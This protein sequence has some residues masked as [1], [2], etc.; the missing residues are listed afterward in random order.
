MADSLELLV[1]RVARAEADAADELAA[2][3]RSADERELRPLAKH[4]SVLVRAVVARVTPGHTASCALALARELARDAEPLVRTS[5]ATALADDPGFGDDALYAKLLEDANENVRAL[6]LPPASTRPELVDA[7]C[8]ALREDESPT[9]RARLCALLGEKHPELSLPLLIEAAGREGDKDVGRAASVALLDIVRRYDG[10]PPVVALPSAELLDEAIEAVR[11]RG[12]RR[13]AKVVTALERRRAT[14]PA[15]PV[16]APAPTVEEHVERG[17]ELERQVEQVLAVLRKPRGRAVMLV[18]PSGA[19]KTTLARELA[20]C[21]LSPGVKPR[22]VRMQPD[23]FLTG[24]KYLGE[25]QT[26]LEELVLSLE[27]DKCAVLCVPNAHLLMTTGVTDD[28]PNNVGAALAQYVERGSL[29]IVGETTPEGFASMFSRDSGARRVWSEVRL[30][31]ADDARTRRILRAICDES[32]AS[33]SDALLERI[34]DYSEMFVAGAVQPGRSAGLLRNVLER[35]RDA[36]LTL[37]DVLDELSRLSGVPRDLVDDDA[38]LDVPRLREFFE[39][40]VIG[41]SEA[42]DSVVDLVTLFKAGLNDPHKPLAVLLFVGPTGV[43]KTELARAL[44]ERLF[45]DPARLLRFDMSEY[46]TYEAF[47]RLHG[48]AQRAGALTSAVRERPLSVVLLDEIEK[49]HHNVFDL[50]LQIFDAGRL[51]DGAGRTVDFRRTIVIM[52]SNLGS[53]VRVDPRLGFGGSGSD[54]PANEDVQRELRSFFRPEFLARID[55]IV[56]FAPLSLETAEQI[57]RKELA[58]MLQRRGIERRGLSIDVDPALVSLLLREGYTQAFGARPLKRTIERRVLLPVA[59]TIAAGPIEPGAVLRLRVDNAGAVLVDL[60]RPAQDSLTPHAPAAPAGSE[61]VR[62]RAQGLLA[63]AREV[64]ACAERW[65]QRRSELVE[66]SNAPGFWSDVERATRAMDELHRVDQLLQ[67]IAKLGAGAETFAERL[68]RPRAS[69][70]SAQDFEKLAHSSAQL[71]LLARVARVSD[72]ARLGDALLEITSVRRSQAGLDGVLLLSRMYRA[73]AKR[74]GYECETLSDRCGG[75]PHEDSLVLVVRGAGAHELLRGESGLHTFQQSAGDSRGAKGARTQR[76]AVRV[77]VHAAADQHN[78]DER[79][80]LTNSTRKLSG[81][82]GRDISRPTLEAKVFDAR[83]AR[84]A[85]VWCA[86]QPEQALAHAR[87]LLDSRDGA[88][89]P[90]NEHVVR[91]YQL[92]SSPLVRDMRSK[93]QSGKLHRVLDGELDEYLA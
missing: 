8:V 18:G 46:A 21:E 83:R 45:G 79:E 74:H 75:E 64:A 14:L 31:P 55:R 38:P 19:G 23:E 24:T 36:P 7:L 32:G 47:E 13:Y 91:R 9:L 29:A 60:V 92:G 50:C 30:E 12:P 43:G 57:A 4:R 71:E 78:N 41:Q 58:R 62:E 17:Y 69:K 65:E 25:W 59:R 68:L 42:V 44:A 39:A 37:R 70:L 27:N 2:R 1:A 76:E 88:A 63:L 87:L 89:A 67:R 22:L 40:R 48:S 80:G 26:K 20:R 61:S 93:T 77:D 33:A 81:V 28:S 16:A 51:T 85:V 72:A 86:Q 34:I 54:S 52:T 90:G 82:R 53:A 66:T 84:S 73:W 10:L 35:H 15:T 11:E 56:H 49:A 5:L 3:L 6:I